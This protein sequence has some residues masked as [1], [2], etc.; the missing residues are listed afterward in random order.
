MSKKNNNIFSK[1]FKYEDHLLMIIGIIFIVVGF[2]ASI[3]IINFED[4]VNGQI[5]NNNTFYSIFFIAVGIGCSITS[6]VK[7]KRKKELKQKSIYYKIIKDY[8]ENKIKSDLKSLGFESDDI[9]FEETDYA[10]LVNYRLGNGS[11]SLVVNEKFVEI[12]YYYDEEVYEQEDE[13]LIN[14][15]EELENAYLEFDSCKVD[16]SRIYKSYI[17]FINKY[18]HLTK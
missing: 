16:K 3:D 6:Y 17:E 12:A 13:S 1:E 11:F 7:L 2:L 9:L 14:T 5:Q 15:N 18:K 4:E 8:Q 10:I